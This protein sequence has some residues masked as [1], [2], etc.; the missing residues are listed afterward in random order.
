M[1]T[2]NDIKQQL[3]NRMTE[4]GKISRQRYLD[5]GGDPRLSVGSLNNNDCLT[6]KEKQELRDLFNQVVTDE[7][8][9]TYLKKNGTW[10]ERY[11]AMKERMRL[12]E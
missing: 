3:L 8:I 1:T 5:A 12:R 2:T 4:L 6:D 7:D 9:A 10:R 11:A